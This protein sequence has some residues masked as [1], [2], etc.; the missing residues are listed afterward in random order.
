MPLTLSLVAAGLTLAAPVRLDRVDV[1]SEDSGTFLHYEVPMAP[2]YPAMTAL[3]FVTQVKVVLALPV[4]GLYAGASIASQSLSYEG[5]L[6]RSED[7]RGLFWTASV[8]TRLLM[9]YGAHAGVAW[10]FGSMRLGLGASASSEASWARPAWTEW[11]VLPTLA[12]G[13][14]P[15]VAPGQ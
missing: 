11:K 12:L 15:N 9:P 13:F 7:G 5:P 8:H 1:L 14:G 4:S 3:R 6:W 10:R 2:A